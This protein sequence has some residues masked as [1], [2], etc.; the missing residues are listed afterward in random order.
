[1]RILLALLMLL[2]AASAS[3]QTVNPTS[4]LFPLTTVGMIAPLKS[5]VVTNSSAAP[6]DI[7]A[8]T[9]GASYSVAINTCTTLVAGASCAISIQYAPLAATVSGFVTGSLTITSSTGIALRVNM[10]GTTTLAAPPPP[11]PPALTCTQQ[12]ANAVALQKSN[13]DKIISTSA[14]SIAALTT[15]VADLQHQLVVLAGQGE[16][17]A[18]LGAVT[19]IT[20]PIV[21]VPPETAPPNVV[22]TVPATGALYAVVPLRNADGT[23]CCPGAWL[24]KRP[25]ADSPTTVNMIVA[26]YVV[27]S[28][29]GY[30]RVEEPGKDPVLLPVIMIGQ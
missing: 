1:M 27:G 21:P 6:V 2:V 4:I 23:D 22:I 17:A 9:I 18:A 19:T 10:A 15:Q 16:L 14:A 11:P 12:I 26:P 8:Q 28:V 24:I 29:T 20:M 25:T 3:A 13:D 5:V 30:I 7:T